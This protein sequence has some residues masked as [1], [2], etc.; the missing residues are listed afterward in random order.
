MMANA[1]RR[2]ALHLAAGP[3]S[4][5][6]WTNDGATTNAAPNAITTAPAH[7][8]PRADW[9]Q[10]REVSR[11]T[12]GM[13]GR[14]YCGR[15]DCDSEKKRKG[16]RIQSQRNVRGWSLV[17]GRCARRTNNDEQRTTLH[18]SAPKTSN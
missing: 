9:H 13:S 5:R 6:R 11:A 14:M 7:R 18:G 10:T 3:Y 1:P 17:V 8:R 12:A 2:M 4:A 15:F 16:M